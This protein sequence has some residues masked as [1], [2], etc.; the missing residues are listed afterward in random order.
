MNLVGVLDYGGRFK[1]SFISFVTALIHFG[2]AGSNRTVVGHKV[3][4]DNR[5]AERASG[6][7]KTGGLHFGR[8]GIASTS[9]DVHLGNALAIRSTVLAYFFVVL[10]VDISFTFKGIVDLEKG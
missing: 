2:T 9:E 7:F 6:G 10:N 4:G 5:I 3:N 1:F 8:G